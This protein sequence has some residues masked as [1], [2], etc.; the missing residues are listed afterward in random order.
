MTG[1]FLH[2]F[3]RKKKAKRKQQ[4]ERRPAALYVPPAHKADLYDVPAGPY[5]AH[6]RPLSSFAPDFTHQSRYYPRH[7]QPAHLPRASLDA[8]PP[9]YPALPTYDPSQY[10]SIRHQ[11]T[12]G[13]GLPLY[14]R[15]PAGDRSS[16]LSAVHYGDACMPIYHAV[17]MADR[18]LAPPMPRETVESHGRIRSVIPS[19]TSMSIERR[20]QQYSSQS[21]EG[22]ERSISEPMPAPE[23]RVQAVRESRRPKPALS[24]LITKFD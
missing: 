5:S 15:P 14:L 2:F 16:R 19:R 18:S 24:R 22:R 21:G 4:T 10:Q 23:G 12:S 17:P 7:Q 1:G 11:T 3:S 20:Q 9:Q 6:P 8:R 13:A